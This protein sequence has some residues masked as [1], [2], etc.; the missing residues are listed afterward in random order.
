MATK[1]QS[2]MGRPPIAPEKRRERMVTIRFTTAEFRRLER[3]AK[4]A[5]LTIGEF[6]RLC[7]AEKAR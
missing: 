2:R 7:W 4:Q 6:L 5:R 3:D 1:Q